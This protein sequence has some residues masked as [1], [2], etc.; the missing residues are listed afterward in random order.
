M[1]VTEFGQ[2]DRFFKNGSVSLSE[3]V[4]FLSECHCPLTRNLLGAIFGVS[5]ESLHAVGA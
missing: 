4:F 2:P 3:W 1:Q 5:L